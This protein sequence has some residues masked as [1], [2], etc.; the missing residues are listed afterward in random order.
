MIGVCGCYP[1][2]LQ[3]DGT[4][5]HSGPIHRLMRIAHLKCFYSFD[6]SS[7]TDRWPVSVI[8]DLMSC[9]FGPTLASSIINGCLALNVAMLGPPR[10]ICFVVGQ[11]LGYY[12]S[13]ALFSL[14]HHYVVWMAAN[15]AD[16]NR[17]VYQIR[18][19][20]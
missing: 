7:A 15:R 12:A 4:F 11:P 16:P 2:Y 13:W 5:N 10:P 1:T 14:S 9:L 20:R 17:S 19:P 3:I 18:S 6:L 8:L